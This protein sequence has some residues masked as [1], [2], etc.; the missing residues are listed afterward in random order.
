M[1]R[2]VLGKARIELTNITI[3]IQCANTGYCFFFLEF[4]N[5]FKCQNYYNIKIEAKPMLN[6][7]DFIHIFNLLTSK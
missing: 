3:R 7:F 2:K 1:G 4:K 6:F 5:K